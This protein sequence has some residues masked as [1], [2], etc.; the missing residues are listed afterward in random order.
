MVRNVLSIFALLLSALAVTS[1]SAS[2]DN[3]GGQ[4]SVIDGDTIEI[5]GER[6]RLHGID[7]PE[8]G[9]TCRANV[10][11]WRCGQAAAFALDDLIA[12]RPVSCN[13]RDI[14]RYGRIVAVCHTG[15]R[16]VNA[17]LVS[18]GWALAYRRYSQ[19]YIADERA[20]Q[21]SSKGIWRGDFVAP[22]D[23]R[24]GE[25]LT[26]ANE[27]Q[28]GG[29]LIKGNI[30]SDGE[31]IYHVPG[32]QYYPRTKISPSKGE[33]MFCTEAEAQAAGWRRSK[34]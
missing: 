9:Q 21:A 19:D 27:S 28:S 12:N 1:G 25:R 22:W 16:D 2:A 30:A 15:D 7:A 11:E 23:W 34:R 24:Q 26:A 6:I 29:C 3:L 10:A 14:D 33:R 18:E 5:H 8:S 32:G 20:A 4:A 17:W 31:R 13:Q